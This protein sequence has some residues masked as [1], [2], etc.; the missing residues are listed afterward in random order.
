MPTRCS[1]APRSS[2]NRCSRLARLLGLPAEPGRRRDRG[3]RL[4]ARC[5]QDRAN[6]A[7]LR[8]QS[9]P[10]QNQLPQTFETLQAINADARFN[11]LRIFPR[12]LP[13]NPLGG[14]PQ[15]ILDRL[16]GPS[17]LAALSA[18][19]PVV[20][21]NDGGSDAPEEKKIAGADGA[22]RQ[23]H[24]VVD[25]TGAGARLDRD[26]QAF[27]YRRSFRLFGY[28][29]PAELHAASTLSTRCR[30]GSCG[31]CN[32]DF[33]GRA[34]PVHARRPLP[35]SGHRDAALFVVP[36]PPP[37]SVPG[38]GGG[39]FF[40]GIESKPSP[41]A[42]S[43]R[44]RLHRRSP[45]GYGHRR[46]I[47]E[48]ATRPESAAVR[49]RV[50]RFVFPAAT[51]IRPADVSGHDHASRGRSSKSAGAR[52]VPGPGA[53]S[54]TV[55]QLTRARPRHCLVRSSIS[56]VSVFELVG[57]PRVLGG[58][59]T[60]QGSST[61]C[62]PGRFVQLGRHRHRGRANHPAELLRPRRR[63]RPADIDVGRGVIL[64]DG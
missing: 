13:V 59:P 30:A 19:D 61:A 21:F 48:L 38:T 42:G 40:G 31:R 26:S 39:L 28:N 54:D 37:S 32:T 64:A 6:P 15:A 62:L 27:K 3:S 14:N 53:M 34:A 29:A 8:V 51:A 18:N 47:V 35:R 45:A 24:A 23:G 11:R 49:R 36:P 46:R 5:R 9:I 60:T 4:H 12:R 7:G 33:T 17:F 41:P 50:R 25:Q 58:Y 43:A 2:R 63:H 20:L 52:Q 10:A 1:C 22:G 55:T 56:A 16:N 57:A 44:L